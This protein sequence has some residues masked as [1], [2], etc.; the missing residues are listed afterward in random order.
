MDYGMSYECVVAIA[1]AVAVV[2]LGG[3]QRMAWIDVIH[4]LPV[5]VPLFESVHSFPL[6]PVLVQFGMHQL[7]EL[8]NPLF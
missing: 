6:P 1:V 8:G 3:V 2:S 4:G 5:C 7:L